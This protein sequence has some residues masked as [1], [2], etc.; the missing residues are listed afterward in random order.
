MP[1]KTKR[2][3]RPQA[4]ARRHY[5]LTP[6]AWKKTCC[7]AGRMARSQF[8]PLTTA[9]PAKAASSGSESRPGSRRRGAM[10]ARGW[11]LRSSSDS[12]RPASVEVVAFRPKRRSS[13]IPA[14]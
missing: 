8:G 12:C 3:R 6:K 4:K 5:W 14:R 13:A 1:S 9:M 10:E 2:N 11:V 7:I